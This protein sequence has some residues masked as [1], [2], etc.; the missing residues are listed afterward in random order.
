MTQREA[1]GHF[2]RFLAAS[3][4]VLRADKK[5]SEIQD[6][7]FEAVNIM[8]MA[9]LAKKKLD[10]LAWDYLDE[11]SEDETSLRDNRAGFD[12]L[13]IRPQFLLHDVSK[14]DISTT[15]FGK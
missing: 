5:Y 6:P 15:L 4:L 3:P 2:M 13:I 7:I 14:I 12:K 9:R 11:G 8:D 1:F 10:P